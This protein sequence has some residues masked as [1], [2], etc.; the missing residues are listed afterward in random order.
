MGGLGQKPQNEKLK[1]PNLIILEH[2][3]T[4][5]TESPK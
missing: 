5:F 2:L 4:D 3:N 1:F